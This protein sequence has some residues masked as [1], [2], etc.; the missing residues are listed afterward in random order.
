MFAALAADRRL[1]PAATMTGA[2]RSLDARTAAALCESYGT[3]H[4]PVVFDEAFERDLPRFVDTASLLSG[5]LESLSQAPEV[6]LYSFLRG[7]FSARMSG[8][9]GNQVGRGGTEGI[10]LRGA[11]LEI[12][13]RAMKE[14]PASAGHWL[15]GELG[16]GTS[17]SFEFLLQCEV[18]F[19]LAANYSVGNHFAVQ[20]SPYADRALVETLAARPISAFISPSGSR[21]QMR[22][23]DLRHR[24]LGASAQVSFQRRLVSRLGGPA[25]RIA[26]NWGWR[27]QGGVSLGGMVLGYATLTG[28]VARSRGYDRGRFRAVWARSGVMALNNFRDPKRWLKESLRDF[29]M[30]SIRTACDA[31]PEL[32]DRPVVER[33][34]EEH[35]AGRQD[36]FHTVTFA[37]DLALAHQHFVRRPKRAL[38]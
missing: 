35:F 33:R 25:S 19:T 31:A 11:D 32:F 26:V 15:L 21:F 18:P 38:R 14:I 5:G 34:L 24:F 12:L 6:H 23:R 29:T 37:L 1:V 28:I 4:V 20:Q 16:Q 13:S 17:D 22:L 7:R 27:P 36:H 3:E 8:N 10:G 2:R 9:L 30:D